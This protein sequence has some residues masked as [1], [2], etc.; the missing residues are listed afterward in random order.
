MICGCVTQCCDLRMSTDRTWDEG[1][2]EEKEKVN[3][4]IRAQV[5]VNR[6]KQDEREVAG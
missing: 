6:E 3:T 4:E 2:S 1:R 5:E